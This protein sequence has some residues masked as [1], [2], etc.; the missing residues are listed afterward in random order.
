MP[1]K[2]G[3]SRLLF[4][5]YATPL[6]EMMSQDHS[7]RIVDAFVNALDLHAPGFKAVKDRNPHQK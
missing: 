5:L 4:S 6:E 2:Q 7:V 1:R 3:I